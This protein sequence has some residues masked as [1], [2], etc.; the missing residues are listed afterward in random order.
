M[1]AEESQPV[2][3]N[4]AP[5]NG[6]KQQPSASQEGGGTVRIMTAEAFVI[7]P[8]VIFLDLAGLALI[9]LDAAFGI[10]LAFAP[11]VS[12]A[13]YGIMGIW[14]VSRGMGASKGGHAS[15]SNLTRFIKKQWW[16]MGLEAVPFVDAFPIFTIIALQQLNSK[17]PED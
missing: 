1:P 7:L 9:G 8:L 17:N 11:V 14:Q 5:N 6:N 13:G 15:S 12:L 16:K 10:G 3:N 4:N 2:D